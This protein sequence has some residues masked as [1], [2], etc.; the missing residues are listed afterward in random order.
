MQ[1][2]NQLAG[3]GP[4]RSDDIES[5]QRL[6]HVTD[7]TQYRVSRVETRLLAPVTGRSIVQR[8]EI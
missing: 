8:G 7:P 2:L 5:P 1:L 6:G 4:D 3:G